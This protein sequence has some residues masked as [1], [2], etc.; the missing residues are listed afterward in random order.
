MDNNQIYEV[1]IHYKRPVFKSMDT[2]T[3]TDQAAKFIRKC[4]NEKRIDHKEF[5]WLVLLS[6]NNKVLGFAEIGVGSARGVIVDIREIF[7][8]ILLRNASAFVVAHNHPSG[9]LNFS[10]RDIVITQN[11]KKLADMMNVN[12]LDHILITTEGSASFEEE[13]LF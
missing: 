6:S 2:L 9:S 10:E 13:N 5:F 11:L 8:L 12:L 3:G 4:I 7:Q 1:E